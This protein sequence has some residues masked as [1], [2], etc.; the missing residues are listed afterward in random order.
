MPMSSVKINTSGEHSEQRLSRS[1]QTKEIKMTNQIKELD[2]DINA[3]N[4]KRVGDVGQATYDCEECQKNFS[5][6]SSYSHKRTKHK[7]PLIP[8]NVQE[9]NKI[10]KVTEDT[11]D[12]ENDL[13][14]EELVEALNEAEVIEIVK[15]L[16]QDNVKFIYLTVAHMVSGNSEKKVS[17]AKE[18][19]TEETSNVLQS[20]VQQIKKLETRILLLLTLQV[21]KKRVVQPRNYKNAKNVNTFQVWRAV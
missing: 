16:E 19:V 20:K 2:T 15:K 10:N 5:V 6:K 9:D 12:E 4:T 8:V 11:E 1:R 21:K 3:K 7:E 14:D 18:Q 17:K 13:T